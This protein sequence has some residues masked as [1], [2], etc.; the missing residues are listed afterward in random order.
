MGTHDWDTPTAPDGDYVPIARL[1][2]AEAKVKELERERCED[3][4]ATLTLDGCQRGLT[5]SEEHTSE[6][7]S[8]S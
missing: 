4:G 1:R 5:R 2:E 3:C 7:Q 8:L 6:L